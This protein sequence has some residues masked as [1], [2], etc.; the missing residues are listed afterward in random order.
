MT[1]WCGRC[2]LHAVTVM[3]FM[4]IYWRLMHQNHSISEEAKELPGPVIFNFFLHNRIIIPNGIFHRMPQ[5][6]SGC[7]R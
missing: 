6:K 4:G 3:L 7:F 2:L 5:E 1:V